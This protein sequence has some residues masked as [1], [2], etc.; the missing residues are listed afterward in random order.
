MKDSNTKDTVG[1]Y[2]RVSTQEQASEGVSIDAQLAALRTYARLQGWEIVGEYVDAGYSGG[3]DERPSL[4]RLLSDARKGKFNIIAVA[5]LDR[6]FR[7]LRIM[8]NCLHELEQLGIKFVATQEG[9]DTSSPYGK[10]TVQIMGVIAEFERGRIGERVRDGR[11]YRVSQGR[12]PSGR[13]TLYGYHWLSKEQKWQIDERE[14]QLVKYVYH[15]YLK[16]GLGSMKIP[17]RLNEEGYRTRRGYRWTFSPVYTIL[18]HPGYKGTHRNGIRMPKIIDEAT[19]EAAQQKRLKV[20]HIRGN[21]RNWLLQGLCICGEC[22]HVLSCQQKNQTERRYY[23]CQG[24]YKDTHLDGAVAKEVCDNKLGTLKKREGELLAAR[25]NLNP[26]VGMELDELEQ[27]IAMLEN[28]VDG[29]PGSRV[30]LTEFGAW[31]LE[32]PE[33]AAFAGTPSLAAGGN[34]FEDSFLDPPGFFRIGGTLYRMEDGLVPAMEF[35]REKVRQ[36]IRRTFEGLGIKVYVFRDRVEIRGFIPTEVM[37]IPG[38]T[39][40]AMGG[41]IICSARS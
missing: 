35:P 33:G 1:V 14:A 27:Q 19:W 6:F 30:F 40:H 23:S 4:Q 22:G 32:L 12:W 3:S 7:N 38:E 39:G 20:R 17:F 8:L 26:Q 18:T 16:E 37:D 29:K 2:C 34:L 31:A 24:R 15:L 9:L 25:S 36:N 10:F 13:S 28:T 11:R 41:P 5:K 21:P